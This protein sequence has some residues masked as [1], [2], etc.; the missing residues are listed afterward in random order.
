MKSKLHLAGM[1]AL[2]SLIASAD[3]ARADARRDEIEFFERRIRPVLV[4]SCYEC[5][6]SGGRAEGSLQLDHRAGLLRGGDRGPAIVVGDAGQE[7]VD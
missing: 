5:H 2:L 1:L 6:N 3:S 7:P 4:E